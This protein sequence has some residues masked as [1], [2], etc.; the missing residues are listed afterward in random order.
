[1]LEHESDLDTQLFQLLVVLC[2]Q[3]QQLAVDVHLALLR[4]FQTGDAPQQ[5]G[6]ARAGGTDQ[7]DDLPLFHLE[8]RVVDGLEVAETF[9]YILQ[10]NH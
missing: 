2:V 7:A 3:I 5:C 8:V 9:G 10:T 1:M 4:L 6:L